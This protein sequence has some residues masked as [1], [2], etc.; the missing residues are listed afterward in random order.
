MDKNTQVY[1][2][3]EEVKA[4][5]ELKKTIKVYEIGSPKAEYKYLVQADVSQL[6]PVPG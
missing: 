1:A 3:G 4:E 2:T 6:E 5:M